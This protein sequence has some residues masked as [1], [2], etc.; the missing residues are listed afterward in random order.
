MKKQ[1][2]AAA[3]IGRSEQPSFDTHLGP[4]TKS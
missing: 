1:V 4:S 3:H 2:Y